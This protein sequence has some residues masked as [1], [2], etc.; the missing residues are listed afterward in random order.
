MKERINRLAKG[1]VDAEVL[2]TVMQPEQISATILAGELVDYELYIADTAGRY[3]KEI[4]R[5]H[6]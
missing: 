5:A 1:I 2:E 6:V 4:G 3:I